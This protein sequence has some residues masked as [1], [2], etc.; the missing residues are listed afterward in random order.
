MQIL[1]TDSDS[2]RYA[3]EKSLKVFVL[4]V[5]FLLYFCFS[6]FASRNPPC[7]AQITAKIL[8][9]NERTEQVKI[10]PDETEMVSVVDVEIEIIS[11]DSAPAC[12]FRVGQK[13][14]TALVRDDIYAKAKKGN[15][16]KE[17]AVIKPGTV[18]K[19]G[20]DYIAD[21]NGQWYAFES[22]SEVVN[23]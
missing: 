3:F 11:V 5:C 20:I 17:D 13:I 23:Q 7:V 14:K 9:S 18:L 8:S 21:E 22:I 6:A 19:G 10:S 12:G 15:R 2:R 16:V 4:A 1:V